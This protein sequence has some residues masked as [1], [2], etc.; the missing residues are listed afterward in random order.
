MQHPCGARKQCSESTHLTYITLNLQNAFS[1]GGGN[2]FSALAETSQ[3][4]SSQNIAQ[5]VS[6]PAAQRN[7][8]ASSP[9]NA[10]GGASPQSQF[11]PPPTQQSPLNNS[12][13]SRPNAFGGGTR[14]TFNSSNAFTNNANAFQSQGFGG[15]SMQ[16]SNATGGFNAFSGAAANPQPSGFGGNR[17]QFSNNAFSGAVNP[18]QAAFTQPRAQAPQQQNAFGCNPGG[19]FNAFSA[20]QQPAAAP[21]GFQNR[22]TAPPVAPSNAFAGVSPGSQPFNAPQPSGNI[23]GFPSYGSSRLLRRIQELFR[24][25]LQVKRLVV[26]RL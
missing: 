21:M 4:R 16:Q 10:F 18:E 13:F 6:F 12:G 7:S 20:A 1:G 23:G 14:N 26:A 15:S 25:F 5:R 19:G 2:A 8:F 17:S 3:P 9:A 24:V 22:M 11:Q